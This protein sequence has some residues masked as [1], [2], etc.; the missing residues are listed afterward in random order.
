MTETEVKINGKSAG[1]VH[2]GGFYRFKY[3]ITSLLNFGGDNVLEVTVKKQS[4]NQSVNQAER[5]ADFWL[6]GGIFVRFILRSSLK[7]ISTGL[8]LMPKQTARFLLM[9]LLKI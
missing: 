2:Q 9:F 8:R 5:K 7:P 3:N 1:E 6:F 4:T